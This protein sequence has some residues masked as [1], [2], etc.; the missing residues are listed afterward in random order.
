MVKGFLRKHNA[1]GFLFLVIFILPFLSCSSGKYPSRKFTCTYNEENKNNYLVVDGR[2]IRQANATENK[3]KFIFF[4]D[5][6]KEL[7]SLSDTFNKTLSDYQFLTDEIQILC[8]QTPDKTIRGYAEL[9][10]YPQYSDHYN[11]KNARLIMYSSQGNLLNMLSKN[12]SSVLFDDNDLYEYL[13]KYDS[14]KTFISAWMDIADL[15]TTRT[16]ER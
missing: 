14:E 8:D 15:S 13:R 6:G 5:K 16:E 4:D 2:I 1:A 7:T 9:H 10:Y 11:S 12:V 3:I